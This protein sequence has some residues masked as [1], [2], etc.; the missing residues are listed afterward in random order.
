MSRP[1]ETVTARTRLGLNTTSP[2][3]HHTLHELLLHLLAPLPPLGRVQRI[4]LEEGS[5]A[6]GDTGAVRERVT[7]LSKIL[8]SFL[9]SFLSHV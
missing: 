8:K 7:T 6:L 4:R 1:H 2:N 9:T 5:G 3:R